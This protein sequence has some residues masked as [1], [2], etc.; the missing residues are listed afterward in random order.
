MIGM[1]LAF[2]NERNH[3]IGAC[4]RNRGNR[5]MASFPQSWKNAVSGQNAT[6]NKPPK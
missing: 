5:S 2:F 1:V 3:A 4:Q 6:A